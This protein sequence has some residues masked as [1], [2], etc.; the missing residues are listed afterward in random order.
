MKQQLQQ[1]KAMISE[2]II[3]QDN[4]K[5]VPTLTYPF[6][7]INFDKNKTLKIDINYNVFE[8]DESKSISNI[9]DKRQKTKSPKIP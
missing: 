6:L 9:K 2:G 1:I 4:S 7:N 5:G 3:E 8:S